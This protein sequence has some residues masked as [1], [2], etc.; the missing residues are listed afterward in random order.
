MRKILT[1]IAGSFVT[2]T[3][4][5]GGLVTNTNQ[6]ASWVRLPVRNAS[7][8]IDAVYYNPAG[9]MK[10]ENGF[11][12][13]VSNQSV[14]QNREIENTF[15]RLNENVY[16]GSVT[17]LA[18]PGIYAAYKMDKLAFSIGF[19]PIGGGGG[20]TFDKGLPSFEIS[21]STLVP[22]LSGPPFN[23]TGYRL[24]AYFEGS[25]INFGYQAGISYKLNDWLSLAAGVRYVTAKNTYDGYLRGIEV[26]TAGGWTRADVIMTGIA[27]N[28]TTGASAT[29]QLVT[30]GAGSLTLAQA[31]GLNLIT[32]TQRGQLEALLTAAGYPT[33]TPITQ[34][35][36][37]FKGASANYTATS[38]LLKDQTAKVEQTG[39]G[40]TPFFSANISPA[41]NLNI[42]IK[43]EMATKLELENNTTSDFLV[44]Y[45]ATGTPITMF[46]NGEKTRNDMPAMLAVGIDYGLSE[47]LTLLLGSNYYFDKSADYG[48]K[49]DHDLN[50]RTPTVHIDNE[51]IIDN[52]GMSLQ[53]GLQY[54][55]TDKFLVSG[56]YVYSNRG[57]NWKYQSDL[58]YGLATHTYGFG[59]AYSVTEKIIINLGI[60]YSYYKEFTKA[61][62]H[63]Q[64]KE[65][66]RKNTTVIGI[67]ADFSF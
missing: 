40:I 38:T 47:K 8:N 7:T 17:A 63:L 42:G 44:G 32:S 5:A 61:I 56:G 43:Y 23:A 51:E 15:A 49:I 60:S 57:V 45:T 67:G 35:D 34:A 26:N 11:H 65:T 21:P 18:F 12:L 2:G 52:N 19:N 22:S 29:T 3:L 62:D 58:T 55:I 6:S 24:D 30:G 1:I 36:A 54:G 4:L 20:A 33:A 48:H 59:G 9:L 46:P 37:I 64:A 28:F 14:F 16:K 31:Q 53:M 10:L 27:G 13:S 25:S 50:S 41:D 66:Y 39:T